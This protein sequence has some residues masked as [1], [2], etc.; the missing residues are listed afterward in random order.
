MSYTFTSGVLQL[1]LPDDFGG[2]GTTYTAGSNVTFENNAISAQHNYIF[3][4]QVFE[5]IDETEF[6]GVNAY[7]IVDLAGGKR[8]QVTIPQPPTMTY[9]VYDDNGNEE[10]I[11][12]ATSI[13]F[14][15]EFGYNWFPGSKVLELLLPSDIGQTYTAGSH[16]AV[17]DNVIS[18]TKP[19]PTW[20]IG[21]AV[22]H[23][24]RK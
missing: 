21:N 19:A 11:T 5:N 24:C 4:G 12:T 1:F 18:N 23:Q 6:V 22:S 2:G 7:Q 17:T 8:M 20:V 3:G 13:K 14:P 9:A 15:Y 10:L 16:I